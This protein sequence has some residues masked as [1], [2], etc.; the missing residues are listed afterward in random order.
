MA[1]KVC[2]NTAAFFKECRVIPNTEDRRMGF[3]TTE[4]LGMANPKFLGKFLRKPSEANAV[5]RPS[6]SQMFFVRRLSVYC[7]CGDRR[8]AR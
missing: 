5:K 3:V 1:V 8:Q 7:A 2:N 6:E 4:T